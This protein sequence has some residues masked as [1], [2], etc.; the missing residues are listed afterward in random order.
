MVGGLG[1]WS[2]SRVKV[3]GRYSSCPALVED[4]MAIVLNLDG[5]ATGISQ[6]ELAKAA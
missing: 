6:A 1:V 4:R 5:M 2:E 3:E